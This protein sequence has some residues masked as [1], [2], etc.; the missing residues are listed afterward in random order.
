MRFRTYYMD[1]AVFDLPDV[2][3]R[4]KRDLAKVDFDTMVGTGF[5]GSIVIPALALLMGKQFALIRKETDDSHHGKGRMVGS[6][7][8]RWIFVDDFISSGKTRE[9]V[10]RKVKDAVAETGQPTRMVGQYMYCD[11]TLGDP[12]Y[13]PFKP[14]WVPEQMTR[15]APACPCS[16]CQSKQG[17]I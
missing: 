5:S 9:R 4:A 14:E 12:G 11:R 6:L 13:T 7:G 8:E 2:I 16:L 10:I 17:D 3:E 15:K 1:Q